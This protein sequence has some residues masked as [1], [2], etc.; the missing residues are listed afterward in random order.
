MNQNTLAT[1]KCILASLVTVFPLPHSAVFAQSTTTF[2][3]QGELQQNGN[4]ANGSFN[5]EFQLWNSPSSG[6]QLDTMTINGVPVSNGRFSAN[7]DFGSADF[8]LW[9]QNR[10]LQIRVNGTTLSPRSLISRSPYSLQTRGI[11]VN[12]NASFVGVGR[13]TGVTT[14][15]VF[16]LY[17]NTTGFA[18]MYIQTENGGRPFY[19]YST[20]GAVDAYHYFDDNSG[21]WRL[22]AGGDRIIVDS[23]N[24]DTEI[25][26]RVAIGA[27]QTFAQLTVRDTSPAAGFGIDV[28]NT[29]VAFPTIL[30]ENA[31]G[32]PVIW[33]LGTDD[34]TLS[35]GG[36]IVAG[37]ESGP[38]IAIDSNEIMARNNGSPATLALNAEGGQVRMGLYDIHPALAYGKIL[39]N[40]TV[41]SSS[42]NVVS[43][44]LSGT[45]Y[46]I[47]I[48]GGIT[49]SDIIVC[50]DAGVVGDY[51]VFRAYK[52]ALDGRLV[53]ASYNVET[54]EL[55][56]ADVQFVVYRP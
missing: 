27:G 4:L 3:Y 32:G 12:E 18:G 19:G 23:A 46:L 11:R 10:W 35:G 54:G 13:D 29:N 24:G 45:A 34:V 51:H 33:A 28:E 31:A 52:F 48:A 25:D 1:L 40:G 44:E 21:E 49:N 43:V 37:A 47:Q 53:I 30:A 22:Y 9:T 56:R 6:T 50:T 39:S 14:A 26:G 2:T 55:H 36:L 5:M 20:A 8:N 7:L 38:N 42:S 17:R 15:E 41:V 16:G